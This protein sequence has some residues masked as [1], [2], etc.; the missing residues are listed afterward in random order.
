MADKPYSRT[1]E[2]NRK[3]AEKYLAKLAEIKL[4]MP[5]ETKATITA[6]A[7]AAGESVNQYMV[8]ATLQR[9]ERETNGNETR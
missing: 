4:R 6:A 8:N 5:P 9:I 7:T 1:Y 3:Y 2:G